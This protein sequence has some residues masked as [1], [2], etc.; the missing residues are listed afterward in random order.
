[1]LSG[2]EAALTRVQHELWAL[3]E[4]ALPTMLSKLPPP[5]S[6][7]IKLMGRVPGSTIVLVSGVAG[8]I[9]D[10]MGRVVDAIQ[11]GLLALVARPWR[12][13]IVAL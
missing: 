10:I 4:S 11:Q 9:D 8:R 7:L 2:L 13:L 5:L 3:L 12:A 6:K 1:M